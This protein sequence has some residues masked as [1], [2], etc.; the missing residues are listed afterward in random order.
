MK[1]RSREIN[2]FSI[3]AL[4]LFASALG[5]FILLSLVFVVFFTMTAK[6]P[7]PEAPDP[8]PTQCPEVPTPPLEP[9][10]IASGLGMYLRA[11]AHRDLVRQVLLQ[12]HP[13]AQPRVLAQV[14][15]AEAASAKHAH[16]TV[17]AKA[18]PSRQ[19]LL[20][21]LTAHGPQPSTLLGPSR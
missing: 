14:G 2:I 13:E 11:V 8:A 19:G 15:D 1:Q 3:S 4:D 16:H 18:E 12:G 6:T 10:T 17:A 7:A 21:V 5:A 20:M 9:L